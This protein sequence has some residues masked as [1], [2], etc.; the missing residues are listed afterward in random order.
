ME[1]S[2]LEQQKKMWHFRA[3]QVTPEPE[4]WHQICTALTPAAFH[5]VNSRAICPKEGSNRFVRDVH[6][7][8]HNTKLENP[9]GTGG[10]WT[11]NKKQ[12]D[13]C[14]TE[15]ATLPFWPALGLPPRS[16]HWDKGIIGKSL[17]EFSLISGVRV[18]QLH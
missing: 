12:P 13:F 15:C 3:S 5:R 6:S 2:R 11:S 9:R 7:K 14:A 4:W 8:P 1:Q 10:Q 16:E 18:C 17:Q